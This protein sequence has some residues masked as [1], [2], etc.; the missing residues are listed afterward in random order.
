[1]LFTGVASKSK[2][3]VYIVMYSYIRT[4]GVLWVKGFGGIS[5]PYQIWV[6][7]GFTKPNFYKSISKILNNIKYKVLF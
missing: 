5:M 6:K 1:M 4:R 3:N 7:Q 2:Y